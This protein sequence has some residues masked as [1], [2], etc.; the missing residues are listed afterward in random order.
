MNEWMAEE[1]D[2]LLDLLKLGKS[3]SEVSKRL[4][5]KGFDRT[6]EAVRHKYR[7]IKNSLKVDSAY[8]YEISGE[9]EE[10]TSVI[11][12]DGLDI[13][14]GDYG[15]NFISLGLETGYIKDRFVVPGKPFGKYKKILCLGDLHVPFHNKEVITSIVEEHAKTTDILVILG[16]IF[17]QYS[18]GSWPKNKEIILAHEYNE[19]FKLVE[20]FSKKFKKIYMIRGNHDARLQKYFMKAISPGVSCFIEPDLLEHIVN[21][22]SLQGTIDPAS[23]KNSNIKLVKTHNFENVEYVGS[24]GGWYV[25]VGGCIFAHPSFASSIA[26]KT[27]TETAQFFIERRNFNSV[28]VG[29]LHRCGKF[30][31]KGKLLMEVGCLCTTMDYAN[32]PKLHYKD[33]QV[34][35]YGVVYMDEAGN[36]AFN[37]S[38]SVYLGHE[39]A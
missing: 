8:S 38:Q 32:D 22:E 25:Q 21:G 26:G 16:D 4:K 10:D 13:N 34:T 37:E 5:K 11:R 31:W 6:P 30:C 27:V 17:D 3:Y 9:E 19:V 29:H 36:V 33:G 23:R 2:L 35:G 1:Y 39:F 7:S 24:K 28:V 14:Y 18:V 20:Y 12:Y 15:T